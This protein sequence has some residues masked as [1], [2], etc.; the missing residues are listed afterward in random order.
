MTSYWILLSFS[1]FLIG[2]FT[3]ASYRY[4]ARLLLTSLPTASSSS[5]PPESTSPPSPTGWSDLPSDSEDTFFFSPREIEDLQ[6]EKRRRLINSGRE[7][8]LR[9]IRESDPD[10]ARDFIEAKEFWGGD[11][12]E[13]CR[14]SIIAVALLCTDSRRCSQTM[15]R[16]R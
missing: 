2:T 10:P 14:E 13:V 16:E 6:R 11:D 7:A 3:P 4:D 15:P 8:R 1:F 9:A 5:D 12:E